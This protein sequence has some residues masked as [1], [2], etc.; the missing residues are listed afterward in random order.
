MSAHSC[1]PWRR[2]C[3]RSISAGTRLRIMLTSGKSGRPQSAR[4]SKILRLPAMQ[5][6][7]PGIPPDKTEDFLM[8]NGYWLAVLFLRRGLNTQRTTRSWLTSHL[9][10][11][12]AVLRRSSSRRAMTDTKI[13]SRRIRSSGCRDVSPRMMNGTAS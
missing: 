9:R 8:D 5:M 10:I 3:S 13:C 1:W 2:K 4:I 7:R 11:W 6:R 12:S